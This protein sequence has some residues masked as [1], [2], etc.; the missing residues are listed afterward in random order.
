MEQDCRFSRLTRNWVVRDEFLG[1][2]SR[3]ANV[4]VCEVY[5]PSLLNPWILRRDGAILSVLW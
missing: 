5:T 2:Y 3:K 4:G 1:Q